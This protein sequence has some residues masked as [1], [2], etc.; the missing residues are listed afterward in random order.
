[1]KSASNLKGKMH[2]ISEMLKRVGKGGQRTKKK[3]CTRRK[4]RGSAGGAA[5]VK[6]TIVPHE[7]PYMEWKKDR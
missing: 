6:T 7:G 5:R 3:G 1:M 4:T 2:N